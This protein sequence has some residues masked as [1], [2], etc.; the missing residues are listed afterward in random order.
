M[1]PVIWW[2]W[3]GGA[4]TG[5]PRRPGC[6]PLT[7]DARVGSHVIGAGQMSEPVG[8]ATRLVVDARS[9][10][11]GTRI[12]LDEVCRWFRVGDAVV[13]AVDEVNLHVDETAFVVVLGASGSG[14]TTLL[15][16]IGALDAPTSGTVRLAGI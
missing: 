12:D 9:G 3:F 4:G 1:G 2:R 8:S 6:S 15:N 16:L 7:L 13:K 14:K 11:A 10:S 5:G